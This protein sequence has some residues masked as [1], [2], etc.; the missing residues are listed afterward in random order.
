[1][2]SAEF[3]SD[4]QGLAAKYVLQKSDSALRRL[5]D[6]LLIMNTTRCIT[7]FQNNFAAAG[8]RP[9]VVGYRSRENSPVLYGIVRSVL[10]TKA[11]ALVFSIYS[12]ADTNGVLFTS[13]GSTSLLQRVFE[14][15]LVMDSN[16]AK[17]ESA[18]EDPPVAL[19]MPGV[20]K[21]P[22]NASF[23]GFVNS[24]KLNFF[25]YANDPLVNQSGSP[26]MI[27][28][29]EFEPAGSASEK[30][31][32]AWGRRYFKCVA[33]LYGFAAPSPT[34][35]FVPFSSLPRIESIP[36]AVPSGF[37]VEY[38]E[39][40]ARMAGISFENR[41]GVLVIGGRTIDAD[42]DLGTLP[43]VSG[44]FGITEFMTSMVENS[45]RKFLFMVDEHAVPS[46]TGFDEIKKRRD[47]LMG[48]LGAFVVATSLMSNQP[49]TLLDVVN[50]AISRF[51]STADD[52]Y[53]PIVWMDV[54]PSPPVLPPPPKPR[55]KVRVVT[56]E[57]EEKEKKPEPRRILKKEEEETVVVSDQ[58]PPTVY[59]SPLSSPEKKTVQ[60]NTL[61]VTRTQGW[62][63]RLRR[64]Q[65]EG[66]IG[67]RSVTYHQT[68][69]ALAGQKLTEEMPETK[70]KQ[71]EAEQK[72][73]Q[74]EMPALK[75]RYGTAADAVIF[76][77]ININWARTVNVVTRDQA[78]DSVRPVEY[79]LK[80]FKGHKEL[81]EDMVDLYEFYQE[82]I[83][84]M[85][86]ILYAEEH[87][88]LDQANHQLALVGL[89]ESV[90]YE[91]NKHRMTLIMK[92]IIHLFRSFK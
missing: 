65:Q 56:P 25:S 23:I 10:A 67:P 53:V 15:Q 38:A 69:E 39:M 61:N 42:F 52:T 50:R 26:P 19:V 28:R 66:G 90:K 35:V 36:L 17:V 14:S 5:Q 75:D 54:A 91:D 9:V 18:L 27:G 20:Q 7:R 88:A 43:E 83:N 11:G 87:M 8:Y 78:A 71:R 21:D 59:L 80:Q 76:Y 2:S 45:D 77:I 12:C 85:S 37:P 48:D 30:S 63:S 13:V 68:T 29:I 31:D 33:V 64:R 72:F 49:V 73:P 81:V 40:F 22:K 70:K 24:D 6:E 46:E 41:E 89:R 3:I 82:G 92:E 62:L 55:S 34:N 84:M 79:I 86:V 47:F 32:N 74:I 57:E 4:A 16:I 60:D 58:P 1:M 51:E 44:K